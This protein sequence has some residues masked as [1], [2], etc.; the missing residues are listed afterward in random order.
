MLEQSERT[1]EG[2]GCAGRS[3]VAPACRK[4]SHF[5]CL[6]RANFSLIAVAAARVSTPINPLVTDRL[7]RILLDYL[8]SSCPAVGG[9]AGGRQ[10][11]G[12]FEFD[13]EPRPV[14]AGAFNFDFD[15]RDVGAGELAG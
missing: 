10:G 3:T 15:E 8:V 7:S 2:K 12:F 5:Q 4:D 6:A 1:A 11:R 14:L 9:D 13:D